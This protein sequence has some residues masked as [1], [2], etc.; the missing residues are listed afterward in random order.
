MIYLISTSKL[1]TTKLQ[2]FI[3]PSLLQ[4]LHLLLLSL[5]SIVLHDNHSLRDILGFSDPSPLW[6][7]PWAKP[8]LD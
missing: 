5:Y 4:N 8:Y 1:L 3:V 2:L 7:T 6:S